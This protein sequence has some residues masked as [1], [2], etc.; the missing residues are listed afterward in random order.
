MQFGAKDNLCNLRGDVVKTVFGSVSILNKSQFGTSNSQENIS[1]SGVGF[2][3]ACAIP[4][5]SSGLQSF[6]KI[7]DK[8]TV[9]IENAEQY[10]VSSANGVR[11]RLYQG[12]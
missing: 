7:N 5:D 6:Y 3:R 1:I 2:G 9:G 12:V 4:V 10:G 11:F 8:L